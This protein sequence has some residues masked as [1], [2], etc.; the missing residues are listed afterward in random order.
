M[1]LILRQNFNVIIIYMFT[2]GYNENTFNG[3]FKNEKTF[4]PKLSNKIENIVLNQ[5]DNGYDALIDDKKRSSE[6]KRSVEYELIS[7]PRLDDMLKGNTINSLYLG[8]ITVLGLYVLFQ[9][10]K[11]QP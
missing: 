11:R 5:G 8:G 3:K 7:K 4:V 10:V 9:F 2:L 1:F 6:I